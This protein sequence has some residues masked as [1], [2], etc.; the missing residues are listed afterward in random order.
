[1]MTLRFVLLFF[2]SC[3][4]GNYLHAQPR[5]RVEVSNDTTIRQVFTPLDSMRIAYSEF[6]K[7]TGVLLKAGQLLR[8][9]VDSTG[10]VED[11]VTHLFHFVNDTAWNVKDGLW[12]EYYSNGKKR[13]ECIYYNRQINGAYTTWFENGGIDSTGYLIGNYEKWET[14]TYYYENGKKRRK[15]FYAPVVSGLQPVFRSIDYYPDGSLKQVEQLIKD[16]KQKIEFWAF[17]P[18]NKLKQYGIYSFTRKW[19]CGSEFLYYTLVEVKYGLWITFD[20]NE[21]IKSVEG[22]GVNGNPVEVKSSDRQIAEE[23]RLELLKLKQ[24]LIFRVMMP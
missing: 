24:D 10:Q 13:L 9:H 8:F 21:K 22:F 15:E 4:A 11:P 12:T 1:M 14:W 19:C 2:I 17:Y 16:D 7:E 6:D 20:E 3:F 18:G 23:K 5:N